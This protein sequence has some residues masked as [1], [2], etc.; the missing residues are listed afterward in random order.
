MGLHSVLGKKLLAAALELVDRCLIITSFGS[1]DVGQ[2]RGE[3]V[4]GRDL[5]K[6]GAGSA[7]GLQRHLLPT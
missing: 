6:T 3:A 2:V 7:G 4:G 5:W 1:L